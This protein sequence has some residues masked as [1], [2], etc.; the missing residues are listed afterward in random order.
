[1]EPVPF[2]VFEAAVQVA[3]QAL[4]WRNSLRQ[5]MRNAGVSENG[6]EKYS[7]ASKY[8]IFRN[9]WDDLDRAGSPGRKVQYK[10]VAALADLE[11]ADSK[12]P[13]LEA[14]NASIRNLRLL[15]KRENIL[16]SPQDLAREQR[17][18]AA[19]LRAEEQYAKR[20]QLAQLSEIFN[21]LH[22]EPDTQKRGYAFEKFL[23]ALF[24]WAELDY[25]GSYKTETD[26]VDGAVV[27]DA[28]TYL[29][30]ARW[31]KSPAADAELGGFAHK[32][33]RRIDATRGLF[34]SMAGFR[35]EAIGLYRRAKE[36]R[37]ILVDGADL[38]IILEGRLDFT[39]AL[40]AKVN[41]ASVQGEPYV[42]VASL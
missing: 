5:I 18:Q 28:F 37:L 33:E 21:S 36:N 35:E 4:Y 30:E 16:V 7:E 25:H 9:V 22:S 20:A 14:G 1:M 26:Q 11:K 10:L 19:A 6:Y 8:Q 17:R 34:I 15:A 13:D 2:P 29:V 32:V 12:V 40:R 31:R 42:S 41:A 24:R 23:A 39:D 27:I 38:A 3:G